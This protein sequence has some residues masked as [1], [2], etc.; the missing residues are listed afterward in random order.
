MICHFDMNYLEQLQTTQWR[1]KAEQIKQRDNHVCQICGNWEN[2]HVHHVIYE[3]D[4]LAW[5]YPDN[6]L[7]TLCEVC[8]LY[9]HS[10]IDNI[11]HGPEI[12]EM[13][14]SGMMGI[15]IFRKYKNKEPL[16]YSAPF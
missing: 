7:I 5:Q 12:K 2:I 14:L 6:Y 1:N 10:I 11:K 13:L 4:L 15:D 9:E 8:H 16:I 3:P